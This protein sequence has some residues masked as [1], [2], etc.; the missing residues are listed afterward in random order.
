MLCKPQRVGDPS[1]LAATQSKT[2][3]NMT[4]LARSTSLIPNRSL[5][6]ACIISSILAAH[7]SLADDAPPEVIII[8][9][10]PLAGTGVDRD[11][12]PAPTQT[13]DSTAI[14]QSH[15]TDLSD[16]L[17]RRLGSVYINDVQNNP[18]QPDVNYRGYTASPLLGTPQGLA[19]YMDG[20]R[21]NQPFGDVVSWDLIPRAAIDTLTLVPGSNPLFGLNALGGA[22]SLQTKDGAHHPG[23]SLH[24]N[25]GSHAQ[26]SL[27]VEHGGNTQGFDWYVTGNGFRDDGWRDASPSEANQVFGKLGW[28]S[29]QHRIA[30]STAYAKSDLTGNGMQEGRLLEQRYESVYTS[31]D[32]TENRAWLV[33]LTLNSRLTTHIEL[34]ANAY[35]RN[36]DTRTLNGDI[37]EESLHQA[38]YQ[39][40]DDEQDALTNAGYSGFP[41]TGESAANTPFPFWRCIGNVLL[42]EEPNEKCNGLMNRSHTKQTTIGAAAQLSF[43]TQLAEHENHLFVGAAFESSHADFT[44]STQ[45]GYLNADHSVTAVDGIGAFADGTQESED[46]FDAR[47]DLDGK[48]TTWSIYAS[49]IFALRSNLHLTISARYNHV[50]V[51][52]RDAITPGG[53]TGSLDGD[54]DFS[55]LNPAIGLTFTPNKYINTYIGYNESNR[56]PSSIELGC[57]DPDAPC[58]LPNA[59]AGDPPLDQ[60][61]AK[62]I[63]LGIRS[64]QSSSFNWHVGL[65]HTTNTDDILF[66][67]SEQSGFGYFTN[68]DK[69]LRQGIE[70]GLSNRFGNLTLGANY[71]YL[72]ATFEDELEVGGAGNSSNEEAEDGNLGFE[73]NIEIE[74]GDRI[75]L[76]PQH[77]AKLFADY[78]FNPQLSISVETLISSGVIARGNE[79]GEHE[80][81]GVYYLD[82]GETAGYALFN[83][84]IDYQPTSQWRVYARINNVF[85]KQYYTAAQ[86]GPTG[87]RSDGTFVARPFATPV[88]DGERPVVHTTFFAPGAPR[89]VMAGVKFRF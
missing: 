26:R 8:A 42:S 1:A 10:T 28:Q 67:A 34:A 15:A 63:E 19:V 32:V 50:S 5:R 13:S 30:L 80:P 21:L 74:A 39:P 31:P 88:I 69:T 86:L 64:T 23:T 54:H 87:F 43:N 7:T 12:V 81:D 3:L 27:E 61:V 85:D 68:V 73:G 47:V 2:H 33:N 82:E 56:A 89:S 35:Y 29:D 20:V 60:V 49:D 70:L 58:K 18:L 11:T 84:S 75:P 25:Y 65:F 4:D 22:L 16:Y 24:A 48:Q 46:A 57:A 38:L 77:T 14:D 17:N 44:Q 37:N 55:R 6:L 52:N 71:T 83:F 72:K 45:F 62:N 36:I 9:T 41:L 51:E 53:M 66:V 78:A 79:N 76:I 40:N 59:M